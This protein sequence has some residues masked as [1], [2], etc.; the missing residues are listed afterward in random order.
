ML[1]WEQ[2]T[3]NFKEVLYL[4]ISETNRKR[5]DSLLTDAFIIWHD[6]VGPYGW[7]EGA[8]QQVADLEAEASRL[9]D[10]Y[11]LTIEAYQNGASS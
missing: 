5:I 6:F 2:K 4:A 8:A 11:G 3:Q 9:L 1:S 7:D 10:K